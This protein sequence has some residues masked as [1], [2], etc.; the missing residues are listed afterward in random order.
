MSRKKVALGPGAS[1]LILIAVVLALSMLVML[2]LLSARSD[3]ALALRSITTRQQV[4][5]LFASGERS[6]SRLD[7][8]LAACLEEHPEGGEALRAA[9]AERMPEGMTLR[10]D[11]VSWTETDGKYTL[12]CAVRILEPGSGRRTAWTRHML[13]A[14]EL[15]EDD[16]SD[17]FFAPD[18]FGEEEE[19][20]AEEEPE[21][22]FEE[23][24]EE[25]PEDSDNAEDGGEEDGI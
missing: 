21:E 14:P 5:G 3:E 22:E 24:T 2:T 13:G 15:W 1:S 10:E 6:L 23:E 9:L 8:E 17:D 16:G 12:E 18:D 25:D 19:E 11:E 20:E 4:Y 7:A